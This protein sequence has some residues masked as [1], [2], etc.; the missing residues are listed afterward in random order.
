MRRSNTQNP[1]LSSCDCKKYR[2]L[3]SRKGYLVL[4]RF[5]E[6]RIDW[7]SI[8][9]GLRMVGITRLMTVEDLRGVPFG[10]RPHRHGLKL[11]YW[12]AT[13]AVRFERHRNMVLL[14]NPDNGD[15]GFHHYGNFEGLLPRCNTYFEVGNL[16]SSGASSLPYYV[17]ETF[18]SPYHNWKTNMDRIIIR[19]DR[20]SRSIG[21]VYI[22]EHRLGQNVFSPQGTFLLS[23]NIIRQARSMLL[24]DFLRRTE[25]VVT[26]DRTLYKNQTDDDLRRKI[27]SPPGILYLVKKTE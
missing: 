26:S 7:H 10:R 15:Y 4:V 27:Q 6:L 12:F 25:F 24:E 14:C 9:G 13:A 16:S 1:V 20:E 21:E 11:L 2:A 22:T 17:R 5:E 18:N 8:A 3:P 23:P 19:L